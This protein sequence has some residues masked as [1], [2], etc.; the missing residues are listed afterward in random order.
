MGRTEMI[1]RIFLV[2]DACN[3]EQCTAIASIPLEVAIVPRSI[4]PIRGLSPTS[5]SDYLH[6]TLRGSD[7]TNNIRKSGTRSPGLDCL[8]LE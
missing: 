2:Q 1:G 6:R 4:L 5:V 3:A 7:D 8:E